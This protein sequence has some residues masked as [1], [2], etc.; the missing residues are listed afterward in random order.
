MSAAVGNAVPFKEMI[1]EV[2]QTKSL[3]NLRQGDD[4]PWCFISNN[5]HEDGSHYQKE[6]L[7]IGG[8]RTFYIAY[9]DSVYYLFRLDRRVI[10]HEKLEVVVRRACEIIP[11]LH[12]I[13]AFWPDE[14]YQPPEHNYIW[15]HEDRPAIGDDK[16]RDVGGLELGESYSY[17]VFSMPALSR[18]FPVIL[19]PPPLPLFYS[20][21]S[22]LSY[23]STFL[24]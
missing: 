20:S 6:E 23:F 18:P 3:M 4:I 12:E 14:V 21:F 5:K 15:R 17:E 8:K 1:Y 13:L 16:L 24:L 2:S 19:A 9:A 7:T 10:A 11:G 22:Y